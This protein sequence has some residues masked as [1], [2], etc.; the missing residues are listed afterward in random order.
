MHTTEAVPTHTSTST[1]LA[2]LDGRTSPDV[3]VV[4]LAR[5]D[6]DLA[7]S[8]FERDRR[9]HPSRFRRWFLRIVFAGAAGSMLLL[10]SPT[11]APEPMAN[12]PAPAS[13]RRTVVRLAPIVLADLASASEPDLVPLTAGEEL[14]PPSLATA[15]PSASATQGRAR[16]LSRRVARPAAR[17]TS[18]PAPVDSESHVSRT[19]KRQMRAGALAFRRGEFESALKHYSR[20]ARLE[21]GSADA[22]FGVALAAVELHRDDLGYRAAFRTLRLDPD[23]ALGNLLAGYL[24]QTYEDPEGAVRAYTRYLELEPEGRFAIEVRSLLKS[25]SGPLYATR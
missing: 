17:T 9:S 5:R 16:A 20:A 22:S 15:T 6:L 25:M 7:T 4:A 21:P 3:R 2:L 8:S 10:V 24:M 12:M 13:G 1:A 11:P 18:L 14:A 23:H 19:F